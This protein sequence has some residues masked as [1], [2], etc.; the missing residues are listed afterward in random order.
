MKKLGIQNII[1]ICYIVCYI[2]LHVGIAA[3]KVIDAVVVGG[4][5]GAFLCSSVSTP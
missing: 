3:A 2:V 4:V 1:F 5:D